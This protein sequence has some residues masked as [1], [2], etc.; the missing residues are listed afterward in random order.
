MGGRASKIRHK[1]NQNLIDRSPETYRYDMISVRKARAGSYRRIRPKNGFCG[2]EYN[3]SM[4]EVAEAA[5]CHAYMSVCRRDWGQRTFYLALHEGTNSSLGIT[6]NFNGLYLCML[7]KM[8][9]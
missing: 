4:R 6:D 8:L 1:V 9:R 5:S 3:V 7:K 2:L